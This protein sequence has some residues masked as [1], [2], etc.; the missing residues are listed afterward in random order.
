M[1]AYLPKSDL[2]I[3]HP[4][5]T[6]E[7]FTGKTT[8]KAVKNQQTVSGYQGTGLLNSFDPTGDGQVGILV[9]PPFPVNRRY[10]KF[11]IGGGNKKELT[12]VNLVIDE[13]TVE[14]A[15]GQNSELLTEQIW[16]LKRYQGKEARLKFVDLDT[17]GWGHILADQFILTDNSGESMRNP[18]GNAI[19][20]ADFENKQLEGWER[21]SPEQLNIPDAKNPYYRPWYAERFRSLDQLTAYWNEQKKQLKRDSALF[22]DAFYRSTLPAEVLEA[23]AANLT[24][25]KS[26]TILRVADGRLWAWEGCNDDAGCCHGSCTH[27]WN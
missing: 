18:S 27:V 17:Y 26:P 13:Q 5:V 19:V 14:T 2:S 6:G 25:L 22:R 23:V 7:A 20:I 24:I 15:T 9:S 3:G 21:I 10:L 12:S 4:I 16:D 1:L 11:L 8:R